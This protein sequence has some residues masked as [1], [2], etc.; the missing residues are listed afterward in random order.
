MEVKN[1]CLLS[2]C[3]E[4]SPFGFSL[5]LSVWVLGGL[6]VLS[7]ADSAL[8]LYKYLERVE[9]RYSCDEYNLSSGL[10]AA[11]CLVTALNI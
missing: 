9:K 2:Y 1:L 6:S 7:V 11:M 3:F 5:S 4:T 10:T 8:W